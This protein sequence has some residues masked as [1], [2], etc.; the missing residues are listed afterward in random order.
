MLIRLEKNP[1]QNNFEKKSYHD[2]IIIRLKQ[3]RRPKVR[4]NDR[5]KSNEIYRKHFHLKL[6][7]VDIRERCLKISSFSLL[8]FEK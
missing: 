3:I 6:I 7:S 1:N 4:N 8:E 5:R 2:E